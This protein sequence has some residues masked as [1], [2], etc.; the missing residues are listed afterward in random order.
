M[1]RRA[2]SQKARTSPGPH[3][4]PQR[5]RPQQCLLHPL[6]RVTELDPDVDALPGAVYFE[7]ARNGV[8]MRKALLALLLS[9]T[10]PEALGG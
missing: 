10:L 9:D 7:Q 2:P 6:P 3:Y 5:Q 4:R 8:T 1:G